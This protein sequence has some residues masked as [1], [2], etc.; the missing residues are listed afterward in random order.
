MIKRA[1]WTLEPWICRVR[2]YCVPRPRVDSPE[3]CNFHLGFAL[4]P[5]DHLRA[6]DDFEISLIPVGSRG[7]CQLFQVC[8]IGQEFNGSPGSAAGNSPPPAELAGR[9]SRLVKRAAIAFFDNMTP[10][11]D[12]AHLPGARLGVLCIRA[13]GNLSEEVLFSVHSLFSAPIRTTGA[14]RS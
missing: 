2:S 11:C 4:H 1:A 8:L 10:R 3:R 13:P 6:E 12:C 14:L 5:V 7:I 9:G